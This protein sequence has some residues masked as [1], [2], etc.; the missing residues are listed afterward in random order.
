MALTGLVVGAVPLAMPRTFAAF[1]PN[2]VAK[3][4]HP[5]P[6][7][8]FGSKRNAEAFNALEPFA[9][10]TISM[11]VPL[12]A[13]VQS[14]VAITLNLALAAVNA[15]LLYPPKLKF[16]IISLLARVVGTAMVLLARLSLKFKTAAYC[17][18]KA[19]S[20]TAGGEV[21]CKEEAGAAWFI[22]KPWPLTTRQP[23]ASKT[24]SR[25]KKVTLFIIFRVQKL[26]YW[27]RLKQKLCNL[28]TF[29]ANK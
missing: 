1:V 29:R 16:A 20:A 2:A 24:V 11:A 26:R 7:F 13:A 27:Q 21:R 8:I 17:S 12:A 10:V 3:P 28:I 4:G 25:L 22:P 14:C 9:V 23:S 15:A 19:V 18:N 6:T 5:I